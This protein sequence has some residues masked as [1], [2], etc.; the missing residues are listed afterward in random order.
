MAKT[1]PQRPSKDA[2][3]PAIRLKIQFPH[4]LVCYG[5]NVLTPVVFRDFCG[6]QPPK[7]TELTA[8]A[9]RQAVPSEIPNSCYRILRPGL[10]LILLVRN[11]AD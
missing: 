2:C 7:Q 6:P 10:K 9:S 5:W 4:S 11:G 8:K 3:P 1:T